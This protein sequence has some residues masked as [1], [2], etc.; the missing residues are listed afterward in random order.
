[1]INESMLKELFAELDPHKKGYLGES[2]FVAAFGHYDW[3]SSMAIELVETLQAKFGSPKEAYKHLCQYK[4]SNKLHYDQFS[5][6]A[7][8]VFGNRFIEEDFKEIW[9][10][11]AGND[12][13]VSL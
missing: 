3:K 7:K 11:M 5:K 12:E 8:E 9:K 4:T 1:M 6:S 13:T 10:V 2:D